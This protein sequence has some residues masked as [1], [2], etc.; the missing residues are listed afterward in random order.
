MAAVPSACCIRPTAKPRPDSA[1]GPTR[2]AFP[3]LG[4]FY[5]QE[6]AFAAQRTTLTYEKMTALR[7]LSSYARS[8]CRRGVPLM[9]NSAMYK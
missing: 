9:A 5:L 6:I 8:S 4:L 2:T 7:R 3:E 1:L